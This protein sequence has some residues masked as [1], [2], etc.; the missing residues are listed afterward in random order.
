MLRYRT[1]TINHIHDGKQNRHEKPRR[2]CI[3]MIVSQQLI[4]HKLKLV[5][6]DQIVS[7]IRLCYRQCLVIDGR[8][9]GTNQIF[10]YSKV[11]LHVTNSLYKCD[12]NVQKV[13]VETLSYH[14]TVI[15]HC[16]F[17]SNFTNFILFIEIDSVGESADSYT[18]AA[19]ISVFS[20]SS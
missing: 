6:N 20:W 17:G 8:I 4:S 18:Q 5:L 2:K 9:L 12:C 10:G 15:F 11:H 1:Y 14:P 19:V 3:D 16:S 7:T 13:T